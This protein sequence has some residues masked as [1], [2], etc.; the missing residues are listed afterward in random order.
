[1]VTRLR[2]ERFDLA[3]LL[4]NSFRSALVA[5]LAGIP[6][7]LGYQRHG[8]AVLLTD[9]LH[10]ATD[11]QGRRIPSPIVETYLKLA[12]H[13]GCPVGSHA[14]SSWPRRRPTRPRPIARGPS[15]AWPGQSQSS[16]STRAEPSA[17]P[18]TGLSG[19]SPSLARRL[20][21]E[22]AVR[23]LVLCGPG[24]RENARAIVATA[25]DERVV[26]LADQ[27]LGIGLTKACIRRASLLVTTDSGPR[28]FA[29]AFGT[30]VVSLF[31]P[32]HIAWTRTQHPLAWHLK[33]PVPCGPCQRPVCP[34]GH[35][36]CMSDLAPDERLRRRTPR[37]REGSE[38]ESQRTD[39]EA[40]RTGQ[41]SGEMAVWLVTGGNGFVGRQILDALGGGAE[42]AVGSDA[43]IV[44]LGRRRREDGP[45][46]RFIETD[47][48][49]LERLSEALGEV[50]PDY[51]IH[52]AGKTPPA[53]DDELYRANF[54][55]TMHLLGALRKHGEAD[56]DRPGGLGGRAGARLTP[57]GLPVD[58]DYTAEPVEAYGR[59][60]LLATRRGLAERAPL[61]VVAARIF[62]VIG[63][64]L[65]PTQA[66][67]AFAARLAE[68]GPDP[69]DLPVGRT[70]NTPR[71]RGRP[72][73]R[74][75]DDRAGPS[76]PCRP[77]LPRRHRPV[78]RSVREGLDRLIEWSGRSVVSR[79][80]PTLSGGT[81]PPIPAPAIGRI[82]ADT[83][84]DRRSRSR[85]SLGDLWS[86]IGSGHSTIRWRPPI[87]SDSQS[88]SG[89]CH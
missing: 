83:G 89:A 63:P 76:R 45:R 21:A 15:S 50:R 52:T 43:E 37:P 32:T 58:E 61:E 11:E 23:V 87:D 67:G 65:P 39:Q 74:A 5:R 40:T 2:R 56:A 9:V 54:W 64:G 22:S 17:R 70:G 49:D 79:Q 10:H 44:V 20:V 4:P 3:V 72:R 69:L 62:N 47:L 35:H 16:A 7:R 8:R 75:G 6:R 25:A 51:V 46:H 71:L 38:L 53:G 18:R 29:A 55:A 19:T 66:F 34:E 30:P 77:G 31:G 48:N 82:E 24:E 60:K 42:Q 33:H 88:P 59:S 36:R 68:P 13:L 14:A 80:D 12:R 57:A 26:S 1:M 85:P 84:W 81:R 73:R 27:E 41:R 78:S 28:H 86:E